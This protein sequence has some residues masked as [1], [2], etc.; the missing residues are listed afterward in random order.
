VESIFYR[1]FSAILR[2]FRGCALL[3]GHG[4]GKI[5]VSYKETEVKV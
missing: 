4:D 3:F 2:D 5:M 1:F